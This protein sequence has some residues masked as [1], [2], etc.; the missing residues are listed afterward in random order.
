[1]LRGEII[2]AIFEGVVKG[3]SLSSIKVNVEKLFTDDFIKKYGDDYT[4]VPNSLNIISKV[5]DT[6]NDKYDSYYK[7]CQ[8]AFATIKSSFKGKDVKFL[9]EHRVTANLS[10]AVNIGGLSKSK[11]RGKMDLIAI[12]DG[13]PH[14]IDL[15]VSNNPISDWH[16]EKRMKTEYQLAAYYRL[17]NH[18]GLNTSTSTVNIFGF[19]IDNNGNIIDANNH[20][21][22]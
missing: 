20:F 18:I 13:V 17:L 19:T 10:E 4:E 5:H 12:V 16:I 9:T 22:D 8:K 11:I 7:S 21:E 6:I 2:H 1:M 15:K 3:H 14:I